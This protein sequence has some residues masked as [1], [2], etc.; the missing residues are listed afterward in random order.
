MS[1]LE[2]HC[3]GDNEKKFDTFMCLWRKKENY[4][5]KKK[6]LIKMTPAEKIRVFGKNQKCK[7]RGKTVCLQSRPLVRTRYRILNSNVYVEWFIIFESNGGL[8]RQGKND[9]QRKDRLPLNNV[10]NV[11]FITNLLYSNKWLDYKDN[12]KSKTNKLY[13]VWNSFC[14]NAW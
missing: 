7:M 11:N 14:L 1:I 2:S 10:I 12:Q 5:K 3:C 13:V 6:E 4:L 9:F 8:L